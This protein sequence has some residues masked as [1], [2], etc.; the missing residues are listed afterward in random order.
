MACDSGAGGG[1]HGVRRLGVRCFLATSC[2]LLLFA[3]G[4]LAVA[5][6][7]VCPAVAVGWQLP[8]YH[9]SFLTTEK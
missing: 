3:F 8:G 1:Q 6:H 2:S 5:A 7:G 9:S 4:G